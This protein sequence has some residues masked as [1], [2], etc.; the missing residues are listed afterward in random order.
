[1]NLDLLGNATA[2]ELE[3]CEEAWWLRRT[4]TRSR[5]RTAQ[6]VAD[7]LKLQ[8]PTAGDVFAFEEDASIPVYTTDTLDHDLTETDD[9][10]TAI[11]NECCDS[12]RI[13]NGIVVSLEPSEGSWLFQGSQQSAI[14]SISNFGGVF[15][16]QHICGAFPTGTF[17][18]REE[19]YQY[20]N[21]TRIHEHT[22]DPGV[23]KSNYVKDIRLNLHKEKPCPHVLYFDPITGKEVVEIDWEEEPQYVKFDESFLKHLESHDWHRKYQI[24][25][26]IPIINAVEYS[27]I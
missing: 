14:G 10:R 23:K 3:S 7:A 2:Q 22:Q 20:Q 4:C 25:E 16:Q 15:G 18:I 19:D 13:T 6:L 8:V 21:Y 9:G 1:M 17:S 11:T 5:C 24:V 26:L 12:T 27:R